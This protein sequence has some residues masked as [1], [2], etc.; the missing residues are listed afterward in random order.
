MQVIESLLKHHARVYAAIACARLCASNVLAEPT[1][2]FH[3]TITG[4][5]AATTGT[6]TATVTGI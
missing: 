4:T 2:H 6:H 3:V 1:Q 5:S